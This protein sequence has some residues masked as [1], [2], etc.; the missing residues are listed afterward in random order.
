MASVR[1]PFS[2]LGGI[3]LALSDTACGGDARHQ[4]P[5]RASDPGATTTD[6]QP[7]RRDSHLAVCDS[8]AA[9]WEQ[10]ADVKVARS[11]SIITP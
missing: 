6:L 7:P 3:M 11:D 4:A 2:L 9:L 5:P 8:V 1:L 10:A